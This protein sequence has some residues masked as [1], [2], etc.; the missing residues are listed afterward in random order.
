MPGGLGVGLRI[1]YHGVD[2]RRNGVGVT[3]KEE[4]IK[5]VLEVKRV[6]DR[7]MSKKLEI[8]GVVMNVVSAYL[9]S[10][11]LGV[12]QTREKEF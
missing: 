8:E 6:L 2:R 4:N 3:L 7:V 11:K 9:P 10:Y 5:S 12:R 1:F